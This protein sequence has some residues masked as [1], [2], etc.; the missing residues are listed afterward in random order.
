MKRGQ[1]YFYTNEKEQTTIVMCTRDGFSKNSSINFTGT[2][3]YSGISEDRVGMHSKTWHS[4]VFKKYTPAP[5]EF[6]ITVELEA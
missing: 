6:T 4:P 5:I 2:C 1:L 3:V